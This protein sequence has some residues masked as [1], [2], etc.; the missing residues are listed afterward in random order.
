VDGI[1]GPATIARM[2]VA[3][4]GPGPGVIIS[5]ESAF[6]GDVWS[7]PSIPQADSPLPGFVPAMMP[8]GVDSRRALA[9]CI[10]Q[11]LTHTEPGREDRDMVK[12]FQMQEG[13]KASGYYN[14]ATAAALAARYGIVPPKPF[15]WPKT[16]TGKSKSNYRAQLAALAVKDPQR[17]EEWQRA[18]QV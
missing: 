15:Y 4:T 9:A 13:Q 7:A 2:A 17:A 14:P 12:V 1:V 16:A 3:S 5:G 8:Q 18:A 11:M 6:A 10:A